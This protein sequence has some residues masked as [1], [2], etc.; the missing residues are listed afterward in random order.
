VKKRLLDL[1]DSYE[2]KPRKST[3]LPPNAVNAEEAG[4]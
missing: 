4:G 3:P 2:R 1:A